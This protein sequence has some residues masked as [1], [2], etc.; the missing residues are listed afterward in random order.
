MSIFG[1]LKKH[2]VVGAVKKIVNH[3]GF[4]RLK[5]NNQED[6]ANPDSEQLTK[7]EEDLKS[8]G[9]EIE[10][11]SPSAEL[12]LQF[13]KEGYFPTDYHGGING[14]VWDEKLLEHWIAAELLGLKDYKESNVYVDIAAAC[15]PWV[16]S[17]RDQLSISAFAI[18][19]GTIGE[20]F[21]NLP[22]YRSENATQTTFQDASISGAS[23]QCAFEMFA[24]NDDI[25][26]IKELSRIL[27]P[28][29][30]VIILPLYMHTHYCTY[31]SPEFFG[32]GYSNQEA[33]EYINHNAWNVPTSRKYD[34][35]KF[36]ERVINTIEELGMEYRLLVLKNKNKLGSNIY[37]H[38]ILEI[39]K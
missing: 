38:F 16:K 5:F 34:A 26:F 6:Y 28:G 32:K 11:Y 31:S 2:G 24:G 14:S 17:L 23:L 12:F 25:K 13:K 30:K 7:I 33:R 19:L 21:N 4:Y 22:Y 15:S 3:C 18:D 29:G 8:L 36:K 27:R 39:F 35:I 20:K 10:E 37:C 1:K 9:I